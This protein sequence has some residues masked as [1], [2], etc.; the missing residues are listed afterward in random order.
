M[1]EFEKQ[2]FVEAKIH[3]ACA[4]EIDMPN[5]WLVFTEFDAVGG[6]VHFNVKGKEFFA[7]LNKTG[8]SI[9]KGSVRKS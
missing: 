4:A 1:T 8:H 6:Y 9:K 2:V 5:E 3:Y 7:R